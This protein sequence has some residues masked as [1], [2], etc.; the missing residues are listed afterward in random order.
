MNNAII[1]IDVEA[2]S[3]SNGK[4]QHVTNTNIL[5]LLDNVRCPVISTYYFDNDTYD[6]WDKNI[7]DEKIYKV[8]KHSPALY[9]NGNGFYEVENRI[10]IDPRIENHV[11]KAIKFLNNYDVK[12]LYFCGYSLPGC[13]FN[14]ELGI[15]DFKTLGFNCSAIIDICMPGHMIRGDNEIHSLLHAQYKFCQAL[16]IP[17]VYHDMF[18]KDGSVKNYPSFTD[19]MAK[20]LKIIS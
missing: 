15:R 2:I 20:K 3:I 6:E 16:N 12:N 17:V 4:H 5:S 11:D 9:N 8:C 10:I 19:E 14:R 18:N 1:I 7:I 13:V